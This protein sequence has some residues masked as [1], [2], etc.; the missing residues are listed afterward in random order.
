MRAIPL[1]L[2]SQ[3]G[4]SMLLALLFLLICSMVTAALRRG[5]SRVRAAAVRSIFRPLPYLD[6]FHISSHLEGLSR[7]GRF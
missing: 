5:A 7:K 6:K 4:A 1:K 3:R 2:R